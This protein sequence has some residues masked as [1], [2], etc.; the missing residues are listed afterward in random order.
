MAEQEVEQALAELELAYGRFME[1]SAYGRKLELPK[2]VR[3]CL[4]LR[5][6]CPDGY[7]RECLVRLQL[8][9]ERLTRV[10]QPVDFDETH[11]LMD[12]LG[13]VKTIGYQLRYLGM[14]PD[15]LR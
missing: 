1:C 13:H 3:L 4:V 6:L 12:G 15:E 14:I 5:G 8:A 7:V 11:H 10:Q 2:V 9:C